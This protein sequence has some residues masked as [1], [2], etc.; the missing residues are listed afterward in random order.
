[1]RIYCLTPWGN[2]TLQ[3]MCFGAFAFGRMGDLRG[4][5]TAV[6][7]AGS[8]TFVFGVA[9]ALVSSYHMLLLCR[10]VVGFGLG[11]GPAAYA[12]FMVRWARGGG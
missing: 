4:R 6:M 1:M 9:S 2:V 10:L 7:C 3:G 8:L 5:R 11:G 12:Y